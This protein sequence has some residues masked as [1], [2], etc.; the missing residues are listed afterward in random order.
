MLQ[1]TKLEGV[2]DIMIAL[3][4]ATEIQY[5]GFALLVFSLTLVQY[6]LTVLLFGM[7]IYILY[8]CMMG[9]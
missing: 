1:P 6:F 5:L 3:P 2:R 7:I 9:L 8:H 4:S